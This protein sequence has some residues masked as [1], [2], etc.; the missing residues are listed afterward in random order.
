VNAEARTLRR[1]LVLADESADWMVAGLRQLDR[2]SL[3]L[4]EF[5]VQSK[6]TAPNAAPSSRRRSTMALFTSRNAFS[7]SNGSSVTK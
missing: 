7:R 3:S 2:L 6:M 5:A 1:V 4:N